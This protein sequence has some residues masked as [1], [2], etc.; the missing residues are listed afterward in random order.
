MRFLTNGKINKERFISRFIENDKKSAVS[1]LVSNSKF[2]CHHL[3][4]FSLTLDLLPPCYHTTSDKNFFRKEKYEIHF[5]AYM[6]F[7]IIT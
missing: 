7:H 2:P 1:T 4:L 5:C 3:P 6:M